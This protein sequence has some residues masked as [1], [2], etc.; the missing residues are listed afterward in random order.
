M[1]HE[2]FAVFIL[3]HG[4]ADNVITYKTLMKLGYKGPIYFIVD[5]MDGDL[6]KYQENFGSE[7]VLVFSKFEAIKDFDPMDNFGV[8]KSIIYARNQ[9]FKECE[10]LG[11]RYA[12][13]LDDDYTDFMYRFPNEDNTKLLYKNC[14]DIGTVF[15]YMLDFLD[16]SDALTVAFAQGGDFIGGIDGMWNQGIKRKAMNSFFTDME[17]PFKFVGNINEDVNTYVSLGHRGEKIFTVTD[18]MLN[19]I[20]TQS[21]KGGMTELYLDGG[22]YTK[23]FY[24]VMA[25][26]S[27]VSIGLMGDKHMRLHHRI[28]WNNTAPKILH[29]QWKKEVG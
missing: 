27:G 2:S 1:K 29:E 25:H 6:P 14:Y 11:I 4:R 28:N 7:N 16:E 13:Q 3:T 26:P 12:L 5:D 24:S 20:Q 18:V 9:V 10:R 19:Q 23:S 8:M 15:D 22:T 21:S 17:K